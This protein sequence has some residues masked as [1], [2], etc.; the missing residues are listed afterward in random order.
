MLLLDTWRG[1][2]GAVMFLGL[3]QDARGAREWT[4]VRL[5]RGI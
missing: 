1:R 4:T 3:F 2:A 5:G